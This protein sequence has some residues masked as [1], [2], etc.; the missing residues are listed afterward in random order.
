MENN[1]LAN[2]IQTYYHTFGKGTPMLILHGWPS[3]SEKWLATAEELAKH[4]LQIIVPD[5]P[6]FGKTQTPEKPWT[7]SDYINWLWDFT[8]KVPELKKEEFYLLGHSFG[9]SLSARFAI[10][11]NQQL[12]KLF[13]VAP[14]C[15]RKK[16]TSKNILARIAKI[17]SKFSFLPYYQLVRKAIY[18]FIFKKSDYASQEGIMKAT[19][20][21]VINDDSSQKLYFIKVPTVIIW[22]DQDKSTPLVDAHFINKKIQNSKLAIITG[23]GHSLQLEAPEMLLQK[24]LENIE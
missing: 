12:R 1:I 13:L 15:I 8:Q 6:G 22:G 5:L 24:I 20:L 11:Y 21:N 16:T 23:G 3:S 18:K 19:Y 4:N 2:N 10:K 17:L 14:S 9:G 7:Q